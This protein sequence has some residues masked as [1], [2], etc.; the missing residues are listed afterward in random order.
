MIIVA[1]VRTSAIRIPPLDIFD[2]TWAIFWQLSEACIAVMM[3]SLI[4]FRSFFL[5]Y[6]PNIGKPSKKQ[7][8]YFSRRKNLNP[9]Q[10]WRGRARVDSEEMEG[11]PEVPRATLTR[12]RT[13][14]AGK[15][16]VSSHIGDELEDGEGF[17]NGRR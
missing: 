17:W 4:A 10:L 1:L 3:F 7:P 13:F 8:L 9:K 15:S 14:I 2:L 5:A 11:L 16:T 6:G 12:M